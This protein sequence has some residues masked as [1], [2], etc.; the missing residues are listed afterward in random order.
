MKLAVVKNRNLPIWKCCGFIALTNSLENNVLPK[1]NDN[2][3]IA[4]KPR[5]MMSATRAIRFSERYS[6]AVFLF[7]INQN[8]TQI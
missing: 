6:G 4:W 1:K 7:I 3:I 8:R 5:L 2:I